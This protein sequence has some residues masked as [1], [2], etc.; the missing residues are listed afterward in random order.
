MSRG[1]VLVIYTGGT[2]GMMPRDGVSGAPLEPIQDERRL[3]SD[4]PQ[5]EALRVAVPFRL[6]R[7]TDDVG[8][9]VDAVDS[10]DIGVRHWAWLARQIERE[11]ERYDGFVVLH[12][13]DT[14]AY[15]AS[16]LS[17]ML[18]ALA[19]PVVL[20][21]SQLPIGRYD[22]DGVWNFVHAVQ[23][24]G[25][26]RTGIPCVPEVCVCFNDGL[27][28]GNRARKLS[29][30]SAQGFDT[31]NYPRLGAIGDAIRVV[32]P[33]VLRPA[34]GAL[35]VVTSFD[36][37]VVDFSI[38]PG[39]EPLALERVLELETVQGMVLRSYGAGNAPSDPELHRVLAAAV[40]AGKVIVNVS[41]CP[42]GGVEAGLY[43][44]GDALVATGVIS[45][46]DLTPEAALTKLMWLLGT[47]S[48]RTE[49][50]R[51]MQVCERGELTA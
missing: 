44:A 46:A 51:R 31:P 8:N 9:P 42:E 27:F 26:R 37:R 22:T 48:D 12:G 45:G 2:I 41:Q 24:A 11:Y 25:Y 19:K 29:T 16:A 15:T 21:G 13:T 28:R 17:F 1:E 33:R 5:L 36:A 47:E 14:M 7:L 35:S 40:A 39:L 18:G 10:S 43:A 32:A 34:A 4:L 49:V 50:A 6:A 23:V 38:F 30:V 3:T 20:T